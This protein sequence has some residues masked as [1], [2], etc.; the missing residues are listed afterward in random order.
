MQPGHS[1]AAFNFEPRDRQ[2]ELLGR[3]FDAIVAHSDGTITA[4]LGS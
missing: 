4:Q 2:I 3:P 1:V